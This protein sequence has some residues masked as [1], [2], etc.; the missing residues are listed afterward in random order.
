V[1]RTVV[2]VGVGPLSEYELEAVEALGSG[3]SVIVVE[4]YGDAVCNAVDL[5]LSLAERFGLRV[6]R[7]EV[8]RRRKG[9]KKR[10]WIRVTLERPGP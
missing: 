2:R 7:V 6:G 1:E 8:G 4:A 10:I 9:S 5:A 3:A